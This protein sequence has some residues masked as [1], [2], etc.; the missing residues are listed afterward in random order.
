MI[1][2]MESL[3][4]MKKV[5]SGLKSA[6]RA[7]NTAGLKHQWKKYMKKPQS[8]PGFGA[9]SAAQLSQFGD[10]EAIAKKVYGDKASK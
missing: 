4:L 7:I 10:L 3:G 8:A 9:A 2:I 6:G 1:S 5:S